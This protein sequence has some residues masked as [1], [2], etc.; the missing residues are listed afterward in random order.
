MDFAAPAM[1]RSVVQMDG[2]VHLPASDQPCV[3]AHLRGAIG[4]GAG[5]VER[6]R[7]CGEH[8]VTLET[9]LPI[10]YPIAPSG[11]LGKIAL[12]DRRAMT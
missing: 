5:G 6:V 1:R 7:E 3:K 4:R 11:R 8:A 9:W 12:F 2:G 10:R